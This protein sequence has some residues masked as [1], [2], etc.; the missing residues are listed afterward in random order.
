MIDSEHLHWLTRYSVTVARIIAVIA[1]GFTF[2][3]SEFAE[4]F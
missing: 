2:A 1:I 4:I 3:S